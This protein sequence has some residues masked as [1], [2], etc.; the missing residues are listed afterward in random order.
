[1]TLIYG[2]KKHAVNTTVINTTGFIIASKLSPAT[3][4][5]IKAHTDNTKE[6]LRKIFNNLK[7]DND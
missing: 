4:W 2:F 7:G 6:C 5:E 3:K 1:M